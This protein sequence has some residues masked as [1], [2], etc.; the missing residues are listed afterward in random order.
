MDKTLE[1]SLLLLILSALL[2]ISYFVIRHM[3]YES[4]DTCGRDNH[5]EQYYSAT[6]MFGQPADSDQ[7]LGEQNC[8][9]RDTANDDAET[10]RGGDKQ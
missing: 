9:D 2:G 10:T 1:R 7:P 6:D 8:S 3:E 4:E 5:D